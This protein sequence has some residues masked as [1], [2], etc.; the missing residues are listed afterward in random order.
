MATIPEVPGAISQGKTPEE[1]R[2]MV[3]DAL[4]ELFVARRELAM[5]EP[6]AGF[7]VESAPM[8]R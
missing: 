4:N 1:A 2:S 5:K 8:S 3:L 7:R 6:R